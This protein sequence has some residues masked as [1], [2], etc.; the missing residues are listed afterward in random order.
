MPFN[1]KSFIHKINNKRVV[2]VIGNDL[3]MVRFLKSDLVQKGMSASC[4]ESGIEDGETVV[5]NLYDYLAFR[6][7]DIYGAGEPPPDYTI[8][9]VV[10]QLHKQN[11]LDNDI[12]NTIK[13]EVSNLTD[14]QISLEP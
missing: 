1:W 8:D 4:L 13:D 3:S 11:V 10:L 7:W 6:L 12:N 9:K 2:P 14:E 5:F